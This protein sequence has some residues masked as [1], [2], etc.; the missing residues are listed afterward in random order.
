MVD[1][2]K[3]ILC[4]ACGN[5]MSKIFLPDKNIDVDFCDDCGGLFFDC[6]ELESFDKNTQNSVD[7]IEMAH[8][9]FF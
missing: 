8:S 2:K 4:P 5:T 9:K 3:V 1:T 7:F 6:G